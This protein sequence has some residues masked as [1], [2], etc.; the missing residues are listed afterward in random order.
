VGSNSPPELVRRS[1][2]AARGSVDTAR[3]NSSS[4][5]SSSNSSSGSPPGSSSSRQRGSVVRPAGSPQQQQQQQQQSHTSG[6]SGESKGKSGSSDDA[7]GTGAAQQ[8]RQRRLLSFL[9]LV[10]ASLTCGFKP[11]NSCA[12][13][14]QGRNAEVTACCDYRFCSVS[15]MLR[16]CYSSFGLLV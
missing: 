9:H 8:P 6:V 2:G 16:H 13:C 10:S 14:M 4:H 12:V 3:M 5:S 7:A 11:R 15:C 1:S